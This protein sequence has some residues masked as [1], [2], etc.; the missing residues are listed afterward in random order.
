MSG[1]KVYNQYINSAQFYDSDL[2]N[3]SNEDLVFYLSLVKQKPGDIL[4]LA[5]GTGRVGLFLASE[6]YD[7]TGLDISAPMLEQFRSKITARYASF[8]DSIR[9]IQADMMHFDIAKKFQYILIPQRSFQVLTNDEQAIS[10]L[11][12]VYDHLL[13]NGVLAI[14]LFRPT[15]DMSN[16]EGISEEKEIV[17]ITDGSSYKRR[18]INSLVDT[19]TQ[20]LEADFYYGQLVLS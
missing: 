13:D 10:C 9:L 15:E 11:K 16:F 4:E 1:K 19:Q 17:N 20:I 5:C 3:L 12:A 7:F 8:K 14:H 6:G 2:Q 18:I